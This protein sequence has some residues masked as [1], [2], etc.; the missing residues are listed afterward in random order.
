V[1]QQDLL[2]AGM[3][4]THD[5]LR[6]N[7]PGARARVEHS[8]GWFGD[9]EHARLPRTRPFRPGA[10]LSVCSRSSLPPPRPLHAGGR[11]VNF[12]DKTR[13]RGVLLR[14]IEHVA[15]ARGAYADEHLDE[16]GS[17]RSRRTAPSPR[18]R[19]R[20]RAASCPC[21]GCRHQSRLGDAAAELLELGGIAQEVDE[22]GDLSLG[23]FAAGD[24]G[25]VML[26][27]DSSIILAGLSERERP[28]PALRPA[29][30]A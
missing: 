15:N 12:V 8:D 22:L 14:L 24:V 26:L 5:D 2:A 4:G 7:L 16:V 10:G 21:R 3:S 25:E 29:S 18:R 27:L 1:H 6:S 30:G 9:D 19:S 20:A 13:C 17:P 11:R 23:L 28:A